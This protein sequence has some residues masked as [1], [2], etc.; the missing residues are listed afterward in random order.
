[1]RRRGAWPM[2]TSCASTTSS[3]KSSARWP[4]RRLSAKAWSRCRKASGAAARATT[5]AALLS[6]LT[7]SPI[8]AAAHVSTTPGSRSRPWRTRN[9]R[10][11]GLQDCRTAGK[12]LITE[13]EQQVGAAA[14]SAL[15]QRLLHRRSLQDV[16]AEAKPAGE[17]VLEDDVRLAGIA[18]PLLDLQIQVLADLLSD[19]HVR[20]AALLGREIDLEEIE[21]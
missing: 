19:R 2:A 12:A 20:A 15:E 16:R 21:P 17:L 6:S 11:A 5:P 13:K 3:A 8:S 4:S 1:M 10:T 9:C 14:L 18:N 7:R